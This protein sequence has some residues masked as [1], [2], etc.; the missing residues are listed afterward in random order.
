MYASRESI[1]ATLLQL[2][3]KPVSGK[4]LHKLREAHAAIL[5]S[6]GAR[7]YAVGAQYQRSRHGEGLHEQLVTEKIAYAIPANRILAEDS[8][9]LTVCR[10]TR[11]QLGLPLFAC[12]YW[13][14]TPSLQLRFPLPLR[15]KSFN[16]WWIA[17][18]LEHYKEADRV[19]HAIAD[20]D[21]HQPAVRFAEKPF[22]VNLIG[23]AYSVFG[24]G[25]YLRMMAK[26]LEAADIPFV[27]VDIPVKNGSPSTDFTLR[28]KIA[29]APEHQLYAFSLYCM[30]ALTHLHTV[31]KEG[32]S[33][34][35]YEIA[36]WFWEFDRWPKRLT[37]ALALADEYW[38]CT[39]LIHTA[40]TTAR[41]S[42]AQ[43]DPALSACQP[44]ITIP[45]VVDLGGFEGF[46]TPAARA[47]ARKMF[48]L[49]SN[50]VLFTFSF[51]LNSMISRKNPEAVIDA[52]QIAFPKP[53]P[54]SPS[55]PS[56][57]LVVKSFPPRK[58]E[59]RWEALKQLAAADP[60][61]T[62][63][64]KDLDRRSILTLYGCCDA[65][66]SLHRTEG[67]GMGLA[68][69]F[70]LGLDVI[71]T[72]YGG[73][74]DFC[75]GPLAHPIPYR[76][77]PV[78]EGEYPDHEGMIWAEP[79]MGRAVEAMRV[80]AEKR[81]KQPFCSPAQIANYRERFSAKNVGLA[82]KERLHQVWARRP[83]IQKTM[84]CS[85]VVNL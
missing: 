41:D 7:L 47:N 81:M 15:T 51:D 60:R 52:F 9:L 73:N 63:I 27:V 38:P 66:V 23:H 46:T 31:I 19:L 12:L 85:H 39:D 34:Q 59:P 24:L 6:R 54:S 82:M 30:T 76:L 64:E 21:L 53:C 72:D 67:L 3:S 5:D 78:K 28:P 44:I 32:C 55:A 43:G 10:Y 37:G 13:M 79:D 40:L 16:R 71:A 48:E 4:T 25:E 69:A 18:G 29:P 45:P 36:V 42:V 35:T 2:I 77:V 62:I 11:E 84:D 1:K 75:E 83:E 49:N 65:F 57:G 33:D 80:V 58:P 26:A 22:G 14:E 8:T 70:Q 68:E 20:T 17:N 56:V 61:I 50:D 74:V